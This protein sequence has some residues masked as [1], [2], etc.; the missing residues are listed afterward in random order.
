[1][2]SDSGL[3]ASLLEVSIVRYAAFLEHFGRPPGPHD[4][5]LFDPA[6]AVPTAA[7]PDEQALQVM[8]AAI[9]RKVDPQMILA[10]LGLSRVLS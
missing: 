7:A 1:M 9:L 10:Y 6:K 2:E 4:P 3:E 8:S 5:L